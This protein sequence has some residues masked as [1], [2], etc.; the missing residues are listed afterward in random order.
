MSDFTEPPAIYR[1]VVINNDGG[2]L[3]DSYESAVRRYTVEGREVRI[4]GSCRSAC[5]LSLAVPNVCVYP[6]AV[7][8][9][10][11]AYEQNTG[12]RRP[13]V[14]ARM[15]AFLPTRIQSRLNGRVTDSYNT[16]TV[17][18]GSELISLGI[19]QC[20]EEKHKP[21][22]A[23]DKNSTCK[24]EFPWFVKCLLK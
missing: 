7:V 13:D 16:Q 3:V 10:H 15:L 8:K 20:G 24:W 6:N 22:V 12:R 11:N 1:P 23:K 19:R 9:A 5:I 4:K 17:L 14:T 2:G 21:V 18:S